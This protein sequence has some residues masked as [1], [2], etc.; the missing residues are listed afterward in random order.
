MRLL[1]C[2]QAAH[3]G[4]GV[5]AWMETLTEALQ[6]RGVEVHTALAK[7]RF[8]DP[9]R[10]AARHR[11][12]NPHAVDGA[13]GLREARIAQLIRVFEEV[14]PDVIVPVNLEDALL[15]AA[16]WKTRG[17][18][19]RLAVCV[20]GQGDDRMAQLRAV[21]PFVD[22]AASVARRVAQRLE[23]IVEPARVRHIPTGVPPPL[24]PPVTR[25][26]LRHIVY[27]GRFDQ[28]DKR[29]LDVIDLAR[30]LDGS[31]IIVHFAGSG[32]DEARLRDAIPGAVFHGELTRDELYASLYP[33]VDALLVFSGAEA[34][35]I[36]AWEAMIHGVVP[37]VADY[38]GRAEENVIRDG[39]TGIVFPVGDMRMAAERIRP[40][41]APGAL[42]ALSERAREG[43]PAAYTLA[44]F[45]QAW[46]DALA[47][48][49][50]MPIGRGTRADLPPLV[51]P[52]RLA[53]APW[54]RR[55]FGL[56]FEHGDPGSEWPH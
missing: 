20:H 18:Q 12:A 14:K 37:I 42:A 49:L 38:L 29:V 17:A 2:S 41:T 19:A 44:H 24:A 52:G 34:G 4:G 31:G 40:L 48:C 7:G 25:D 16:L 6:S 9:D 47:D 43:L 32:P 5:E 10:Y 11:V 26:R 36:V 15:A 28:R 30:A 27:A 35:P 51:S 21:A 13:A 45:G 3:T 54:I 56:R 50:R 1:F 8:H 33:S 53:G 55:L 46:Y 23:S 22:L 39:D